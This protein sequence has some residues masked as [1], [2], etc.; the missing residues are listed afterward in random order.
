[1]QESIRETGA[2]KH[3]EA[4]YWAIVFVWAGLIFGVDSLGLLPQIGQAGAWSWVFGGAGLLSLLGNVWRA[5]SPEWPDATLWDYIWAAI[6]LIIGASGFVSNADIA[7]PII[8]VVIGVA[9]LASMLMSREEVP[10][11]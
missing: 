4:I 5:A 9:I 2:R 6:L 11:S 7:F 1:M 3:I 8:L 10:L